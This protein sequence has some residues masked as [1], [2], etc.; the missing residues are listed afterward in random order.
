MVMRTW[1]E[2]NSESLTQANC[3][4]KFLLEF[5]WILCTKKDGNNN[6][7]KKV[8]GGGEKIKVRLAQAILLSHAHGTFPVYLFHEIS[9]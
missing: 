4:F 5:S 2:G 3:T 8:G 1:G 9:I 6:N 7:K